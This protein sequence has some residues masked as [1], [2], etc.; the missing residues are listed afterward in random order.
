MIAQTASVDVAWLEVMTQ[1][2][3]GEQRCV[4]CLVAKV[5]AELTA[6]Q[7]RTAVGLGGNEFC[8]TLTAQVVAHKGERDTTEVTTATEAANHNIRIFSCHL[9]L[10][11]GL[12]TDDGLVQTNMIEHRTECIFAIGSCCCQFHGFR[13]SS[14]QRS[15]VGRILGQDILTSTG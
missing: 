8:V 13:D 6:G 11:L 14:T 3:H 15:A 4:A 7:L 9:H 12:Q 2:E 5:V 1:G 10:L